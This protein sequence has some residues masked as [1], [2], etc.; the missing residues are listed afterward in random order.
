MVPKK[1]FSGSRKQI[2]PLHRRLKRSSKTGRLRRN[3][4]D[5]GNLVA[6]SLTA[7]AVDVAK[8]VAAEKLNATAAVLAVAE[9]GNFD[10]K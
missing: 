4:F 2:R 9:K 8:D 3:R 1:D 10:A 5:T 7:A 6:L